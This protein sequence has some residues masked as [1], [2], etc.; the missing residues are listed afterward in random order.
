MRRFGKN[1]LNGD[2][3]DRP[4]DIRIEELFKLKES[5]LGGSMFS[6]GPVNKYSRE[7]KKKRH[8]KTVKNHIRIHQ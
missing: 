3:N 2:L 5:Y 1:D 6:K 4:N 8:S 7:K